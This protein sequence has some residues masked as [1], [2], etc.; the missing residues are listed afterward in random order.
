MDRANVP[1][2]HLALKAAYGSYVQ[3]NLNVLTSCLRKL[4]TTAAGL[5]YLLCC[6]RCHVYPTFISRS[7][8]FAKLGR[9]LERLA[10]RLPQ[11]MLRAAIRDVRVRFLAL[12]REV[13]SLWA[14]LFR[15][16]F[17]A[18]LWNALVSQKDS[19]FFTAHSTA[20]LHLKRKFV[21][22]FAVFPNDSYTD[23]VPYRANQSNKDLLQRSTPIQASSQRLSE[24][25]LDLSGRVEQVANSR[26]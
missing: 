26:L 4:A 11:R 13:D 2:L 14:N 25:D 3:R 18:T 7:I 10:T 20:S 5:E 16:V 6:R 9:N 15:I 1:S 17:D 8:K 19:V 24:T 12:E 22:L 23:D 21:A